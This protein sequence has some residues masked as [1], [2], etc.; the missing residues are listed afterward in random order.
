MSRPE[1]DGGGGLGWDDVT[2][3]KH[4]PVEAA[5]R[6]MK[7]ARDRALAEAEAF[8]DAVK[9]PD[10]RGDSADAAARSARRLAGVGR[11]EVA[12]LTYLHRGLSDAADDVLGIEKDVKDVRA[13]ADARHLHIGTAGL[14]TDALPPAPPAPG[15]TAQDATV[16]R[17]ERQRLVDETVA[18]M[19]AV[20]TRAAAVDAALTVVLTSVTTGRRSAAGATT[21]AQAMSNAS[22]DTSASMTPPPGASPAQAAG[23]WHALSDADRATVQRDHPEWVGNL[24]GIPASVRDAA[25]RERARRMRQAAEQDLHDLQG[26]LERA[27]RMGLSTGEITREMGRLRERLDSLTAVETTLARGGRQLLTL[28]E[29]GERVRAAVAIGDIDTADHVSVFVPGTRTNVPESLAGYDEQMQRLQKTAARTLPPGET[30]AVV[31]WLG[32]EAPQLHADTRA[33]F[34][35]LADDDRVIAD[36]AATR[37]APALSRFLNGI[38]SARPTHPHLSLVGHSYGTLVASLAAQ[39]GTGVDEV[40]M[41]GSPGAEVTHADQWG[42]RTGHAYHLGYRDD[43]VDQLAQPEKIVDPVTG[44]IPTW[45]PGRDWL[46][47]EAVEQAYHLQPF[48]PDLDVVPG[49]TTLPV[50]G[51]PAMTDARPPLLTQPSGAWLSGQPNKDP[52]SIHSSYTDEGSQAQYQIAQVIAGRQNRLSP[53]ASPFTWPGVLTTAGRPR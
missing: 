46:R 9:V 42:T 8:E 32:Y 22:A 28:D 29:T 3:W 49:V 41:L 18:R 50:S 20:L 6:A 12:D 36:G 40:V 43:P 19:D 14:V 5:S 52:F 16:D 2:Q 27:Q 13:L 11:E 34:E 47:R 23:W 4:G 24:D 48:G 33:P 53:A 31:S 17:D 7:A 38:D 51:G 39:Q 10:W 37:G 45:V 25:N 26:D 35:L 30:V 1:G 21:L 44:R 15:T